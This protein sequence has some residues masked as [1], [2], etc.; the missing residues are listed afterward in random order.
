MFVLCSLLEPWTL[1]LN[2]FYFINML[3]HRQQKHL[4]FLK[5]QIS[6]NCRWK[7]SLTSQNTINDH[8]IANM[9]M[10]A[11]DKSNFLILELSKNNDAVLLRCTTVFHLW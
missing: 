2:Q 11:T 5:C 10:V 9:L 7:L 6:L 8:T 4:Y 3:F 1:F